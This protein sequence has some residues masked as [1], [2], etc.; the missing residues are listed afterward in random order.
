MEVLFVVDKIEDLDKKISIFD[1]LGMDI[2]FF[3]SSKLVANLINNKYVVDR[4][5]AIYKNNVNITIDKYLKAETYKPTQT[6]LYYSS[7]ELSLEKL[8]QIRE[9]LK[10][11][12][13]VL[14]VKKK[15]TFWDKFKQWFYQKLVKLI[16]GIHDAFA[17]V[18]LQYFSAEVMGIFVQTNFKNHIFAL[19]NSVSI[20]LEKGEEK[21]YYDKPKFRA[22]TLYNPIVI[23]LI[24]ICYVVL[25]KFL[26]LPFWSYFLVVALLLATIINWIVMVIKHSFDARYKK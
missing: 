4:I 16:F 15:F 6:I 26:A 14:Y 3:V 23:C 17:S 10:I 8:E 1:D 5:V 9:K 11:D 20:E 12:P 2:K 25:E 7:A 22:I 21:T 13:T 19:P 18:K 24:L